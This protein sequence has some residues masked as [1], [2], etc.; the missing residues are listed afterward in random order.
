MNSNADKLTDERFSDLL[1]SPAALTDDAELN[2]LK[3][4]LG[5]Y[6]SETLLW[7]ERRS[8]VQPS[9]VPAAR[10]NRFWSMASL[11]ARRS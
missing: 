10:S 11:A 1:A 2:D 4:A 9:L 5:S 3:A 6:R 7:A 8:A